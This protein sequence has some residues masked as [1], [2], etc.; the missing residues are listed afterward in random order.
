MRLADVYLMYAEATNE[1]SGPQ[2]DAIGF[3]N[4]V[5]KRGN[6]PALAPAKTVSKQTFFDAI[7]Q[8]RIIELVAEGQRSFDIRRWRSI[9]KIWGAPGGPGVWMQ[10]TWGANQQRY[11]LNTVDLTYKQNYIFRIPPGERDRNANLTQNI[12]WR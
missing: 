4:L 2:A 3:V 6:L 5:R 10:D 1:V 9:E 8:E 7:E 11:Y 12:P